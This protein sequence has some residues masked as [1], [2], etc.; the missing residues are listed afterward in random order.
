MS[1]S[2]RFLFVAALVVS[3]CDRRLVLV[4]E[5]DAST[6]DGSASSNAFA[7]AAGVDHTCF[8]SSGALYCTGHDTSGQ[9]GFPDGVDRLVPTVVDVGTSW[10]ALSLGY[11]AT[12]LLD[13]RGA[14]SCLGD[15]AS[16]QLATGDA[17][18][19]SSPTRV[20][21]A[22]PVV[23]FSLR[24]A[25]ACAV[26][27]DASLWCWGSN[28]EGELGQSDGG[29]AAHGVPVRVSPELSWSEASC[30]QGHTC[31]ITRDGALYC[32]GRNGGVLGLGPALLTETSTPMRAG[33]GSWRHV[34]AGQNHTCGIASDGT[35]ACWGDDSNADGHAGPVGLPGESHT[36]VPTTVDGGDWATVSTDTFHTCGVRTNG[37]LWCWGRNIEGQLG[38]GMLEVVDTPLRIGTDS[39]WAR[40]AV[41]RFYTC[42]QKRDGSV[43]CTGANDFGE[44]GIGVIERRNVLT[45]IGLGTP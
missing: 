7:L 21:L 8:L 38:T 24:F 40:V 25:H 10:V 29:G 31:A 20:A 3:G 22:R 35:L 41:G 33:S 15:N 30:G 5:L 2:A 45:R 9:L 28:D 37:E 19:R 36:S 1:R 32:W 34:V 14:L 4:H 42:A 11:D 43:W 18:A 6:L 39:D 12:C 27:D 13:V 26:L 16:R 23:S 44:T 17:I